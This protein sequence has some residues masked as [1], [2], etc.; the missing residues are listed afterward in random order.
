MPPARLLSTPRILALLLL[1]TLTAPLCAASPRDELLRYV[2][3][4]VGFCLIVTDLRGHSAAL[5][6]SPF[7]EQFRASPAGQALVN[8]PEWKQLAEV[9]QQLQKALG[10]GWIG[11]RDDI[12]GDAF[13]FA[14][15]PGPPDQPMKEEGLV[16]V[17]ARDEKKLAE[18]I[19]RLNRLQKE[20]GE[21]E[22]L[23][24]RQHAGFKY[25]CRV[26]KKGKEPTFYYQAGP[27]LLFTSQEAMLKRSLERSRALA[28][29]AAAPLTGK[30]NKLGGGGAV[31]ALWVN[32]RAFDAAIEAR[33][34][35]GPDDVALRT[36]AGYWKALDGLLLTV[37]LDRELTIGLA[38][39]ART[40]ALPPAARR[41]LSEASQASDLWRHF[42]DDA[43]FAAAGRIDGVALLEA[44]SE[45][46]PPEQ[47]TLLHDELNRSL[48]APLGKKNFLKEVLPFIGP[49]WGVC[50]VA[51]PADG[52]SWF[53]Q[54]VLAVRI[55][56]GDRTAPVDRAVLE[57]VKAFA[58]GL[59]VG[60][61]Q[62][63][64]KAILSLKTVELD[65]RTI[66]YLDGPEALPPGLQPAFALVNGHLLLAS[67]PEV[68]RRFG[69][70]PG[71]APDPEAGVPLL[72]VSFKAWRAFLRQ[73]REPII[74]FLA[75]KEKL[76]PE[77][78]AARLDKTLTVL[79][80]I[81][82]VEL[83]QK[84]GAGQVIL[85]LTITPNKPLRK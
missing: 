15:R 6:D 38:V 60:H 7:A 72:R 13:V 50:V 70:S 37:R 29:D 42:P 34:K 5:A 40:D 52:Q 35:A 83:K 49:D 45:F 20:S 77:E 61:N 78:I 63:H 21:L 12:L 19:E 32:P 69:T 28:P 23:E 54:G 26:E 43:L 55:A 48:A 25:V 27:V 8:A 65:G 53:P 81:D 47:R 75:E 4:D 51:P 58:F 36:F 73:R 64:P 30:L 44:L 2:P 1:G 22:R 41:F 17:R 82:R 74:A 46:L 14:Y 39:E 10:V 67:S 80:F 56:P 71:P 16:L 85:T 33:G 57:A 84:S 62:T 18:L 24:E 68:I 59:V 31:L 66:Q 3:E 9:D 11:L 79:E 76:P